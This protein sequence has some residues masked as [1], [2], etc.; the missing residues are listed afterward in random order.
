MAEEQGNASA[1]ATSEHKQLIV[2]RER[3]EA[4]YAQARETIDADGSSAI[5]Y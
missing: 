2:N 4:I 1:M 5:T 3:L